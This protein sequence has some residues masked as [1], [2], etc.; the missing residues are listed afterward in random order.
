MDNPLKPTS[1]QTLAEIE[2]IKS[3]IEMNQDEDQSR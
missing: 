1:K 2:Q 3:K